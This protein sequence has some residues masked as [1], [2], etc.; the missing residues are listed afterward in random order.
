MKLYRSKFF[1]NRPYTLISITSFFVMASCHGPGNFPS[2]RHTGRHKAMKKIS[3]ALSRVLLPSLLL[4]SFHLIYFSHYHHTVTQTLVLWPTS[5]CEMCA[6]LLHDSLCRCQE[7]C[8]S[9]SGVK[10]CNCLSVKAWQRRCLYGQSI[11]GSSPKRNRKGVVTEE[12]GDIC[13]G[14]LHLY[15]FCT[16]NGERESPLEGI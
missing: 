12:R 13:E 15:S 9:W 3:L 1:K 2:G 6:L 8:S 14:C 16:A 10:N 4:S 11:L 5:S 7:S